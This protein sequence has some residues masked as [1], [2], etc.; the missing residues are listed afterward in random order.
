MERWRKISYFAV[1]VVTVASAYILYN[2]KHE[3]NDDE[4]AYEHLNVIHK[5]SFSHWSETGRKKYRQNFPHALIHGR[6]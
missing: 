3:Y 1:T 4:R 2:D 6:D 5:V